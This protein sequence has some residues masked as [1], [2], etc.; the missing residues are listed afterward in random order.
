MIP[1]FQMTNT[2]LNLMVD[3][4]QTVTR[5]EISHERQLH[6]RKENRIRSIHSS[7]AIEKNSLSLEQVTDVINGKRVLGK[8]QEIREVQN[9]YE[10]YERVFQLNPYDIDDFLLAHHL[11]TDELITESGQFRS[12]DVGVFDSQGNVVHV[13]ARPQFVSILIKELFEWAKTSDVPDL[14]KSC[15]VHFELEMIHPFADGNGRMGRVWQNLILSQWH[16]IFEWIP[17]ETIVYQNQQTYYD[18]LEIC[19]RANDSSAFIEFMLEVIHQTLQEF[20][21]ESV[22]VLVPTEWVNKLSKV[23]LSFFN[24]L[25]PT[26]IKQGEI[27]S[28]EACQISGKSLPTVHRHLSVLIELGILSKEG[29]NRNRRYRLNEPQ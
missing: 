2:M 6:L 19:N 17:I 24:Q 10:A 27:T 8:P 11:M 15:V 25:Y 1:N 20:G 13:G 7:L 14:I 4:T 29:S 22:E 9:A 28:Q 23:Q 21:S 3:I 26:L 16:P 5:L 18:K 12:G